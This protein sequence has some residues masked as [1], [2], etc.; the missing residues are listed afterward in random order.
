M[1][2]NMVITIV[3]NN[4]SY[5]TDGQY[6]VHSIEYINILKGLCHQNFYLGF[7]CSFQ[8]WFMYDWLYI[9]ESF[10]KNQKI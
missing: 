1:S 2:G 4:A 5:P 7:M 6:Y 8:Y 9:Q 10:L 3:H